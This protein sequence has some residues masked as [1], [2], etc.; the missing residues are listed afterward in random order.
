[1]AYDKEIDIGG[2][3]TGRVYK[4]LFYSAP[5]LIGAARASD[6]EL[7]SLSEMVRTARRPPQIY[8]F[9]EFRKR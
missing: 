6:L 9:L 4:A 2:P 8:Q 5:T 1:M 3:H 7:V